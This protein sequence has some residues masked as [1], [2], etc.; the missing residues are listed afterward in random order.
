[1]PIKAENKNLYPTNW[2]EIRASIRIRAHDKCEGCGL[3]DHS[4]GFRTKGGQFIPCAGNVTM[5]D[6]GNGIDPYTGGLLNIKRAREVAEFQ[7]QTDEY[8][9]KYFVIICTVAHLDHNP[10]NCKEDNLRFWCQKCHNSYDR[11]HRDET[12]KQ[13]RMKGQMEFDFNGQKKKQKELIGYWAGI[14][15]EHPQFNDIT[16]FMLDD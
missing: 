2:N 16:K 7:T 9:N 10:Q 12:I 13:V 5:D 1:M 8:G 4:I 3:H 6:Y 14:V 15:Q 11:P